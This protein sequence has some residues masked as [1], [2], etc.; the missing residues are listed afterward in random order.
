MYL[1]GKLSFSFYLCNQAPEGWVEQNHRKDKP[2]SISAKDAW[3]KNPIHEMLKIKRHFTQS[4][5]IVHFSNGE[6]S[7]TMPSL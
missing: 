6:L 4:L 7:R 3:P 1:L 5:L 2:V